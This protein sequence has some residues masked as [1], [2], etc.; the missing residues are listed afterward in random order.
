VS[1]A[2]KNV[3]WEFAP[4]EDQLVGMLRSTLISQAGGAGDL[5]VVAE[6]QRRFKAFVSGTDESAVHPSLRLSIFRL[7]VSTGGA[8]ELEEVKKF[9]ASTT[10][11][12]G[13]EIALQSMGSVQTSE[14]AQ[15][16]LDFTFSPAVAIQDK[17]SPAIAL[18]AN[19]A[20]RGELWKYVKANWD[21]KI[22]SQLSGNMIV[23]ERWL[24]Y[25]LNKYSDFEIEKDI[26]KF[27]ENK[28]QKGYD[29]G[30]SVVRDT[31]VGAA[32]YKERDVER[33]REWLSIHGYM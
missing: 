16:V 20:Q 25:G 13:K 23:L 9:Y 22:Y 21:D 15:G 6:A 7:A 3:G 11:I 31:I 4:N 30:L 24:R 10:S 32:K 26:G 18:A 28:D 14:L 12:D 29:R 33:V 5:A 2:F 19:S 17:H 1:P 8:E 27:F